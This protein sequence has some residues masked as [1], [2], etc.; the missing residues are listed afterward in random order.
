MADQ[1]ERIFLT[2]DELSARWKGKPKPTTLA[3]WRWQ[4]IGPKAERIGKQ[5]R[6]LLS[7]VEAWETK[8]AAEHA[9]AI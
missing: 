1:K 3:N 2:P 7:E 9:I 4:G 6:Y 8:N 5:V